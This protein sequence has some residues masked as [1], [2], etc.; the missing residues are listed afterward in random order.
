MGTGPTHVKWRLGLWWH[1]AELNALI[2]VLFVS[3]IANKLAIYLVA[4]VLHD[5]STVTSAVD[6]RYA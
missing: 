5:L 2:G 4:R 6:E 1:P 3:A